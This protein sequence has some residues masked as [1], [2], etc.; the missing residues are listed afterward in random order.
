LRSGYTIAINPT[1][2]GDIPE[3]YG[4][5]SEI[6]I[7]DEEEFLAKANKEGDP[8]EEITKRASK[9]DADAID[10]LGLDG[11]LVIKDHWRFYPAESMASHTLGFVG[12]K[13]DELAGRYGLE[14]FY[15]DVLSRNDTSLYV[16]FFA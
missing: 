9:E 8:Y 14:R 4:H 10:A 7:L 13:G 5:L 15:N 2:L 1:N 12:Y 6:L 11:V 3:T 16:N